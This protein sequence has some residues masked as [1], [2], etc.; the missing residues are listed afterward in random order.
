MPSRK[1]NR[2]SIDLRGLTQAEKQIGAF[3]LLRDGEYRVVEICNDHAK[4]PH[5]KLEL[6]SKI[7]PKPG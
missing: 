5:A 1:P 3:V 4:N 7:Q 2:R 6:V